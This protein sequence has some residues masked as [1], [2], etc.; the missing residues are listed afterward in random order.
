[1]PTNE[2][3]PT[4]H[5][6]GAHTA[7]AELSA[8]GVSI[9]LDDLSRARIESGGLQ[10]LIDTR[11]IVGVTTNPTIF[12]K[13]ISK[14]DAY[15][16]Q[17]TELAKANADAE[18]AVR[19]LTTADVASAADVLRPVFEATD[20]LDGR[21][22]IEVDPFLAHDAE[23]TVAQ[24]I[25]LWQTIDRPNL[26]I[27]IPAT[28]EGLAAITE[29]TA[30]GISVNV[31]LIFGLPRYREVINAYLLGLERALAAGIDISGIHSVASFFVSRVDVEVNRVLETLGLQPGDGLHNTA[32]LANARAAYQVFLDS[33]DT[34]RWRLLADRGA[35]LQR[36]LW[37]STGVKD[38][39]LADTTYVTGLVADHT[40]NTVPEATLEATDDHGVVGSVRIPQQIDAAKDTLDRIQAV[41]VSLSEVSETLEREGVT[42]FT[43]AWS[44]LLSTVAEALEERR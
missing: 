19:A 40:V 29:A 24:A 30:A 1:M 39:S 44:H 28:V 22:S 13:A 35:N 8:A 17:L 10:Q 26:F 21:V 34:E 7:L 11:H 14:G 25:D 9:W 3:T 5:E 20:G 33:L 16:A 42:K 41:G 36:P 12:D 18:Q 31:T 4:A 32:A 23:A 27:K 43:D 2:T 37:A 38:P 6:S 15:D